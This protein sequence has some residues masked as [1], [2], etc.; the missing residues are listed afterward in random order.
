MLCPCV[1]LSFGPKPLSPRNVNTFKLWTILL[2]KAHY[3]AR[4]ELEIRF[5]L[6]IIWVAGLGL[7]SFLSVISLSGLGKIKK[8]L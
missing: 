3:G 1:S 2:A 4:N 8:S 5:S 6:F 7:C